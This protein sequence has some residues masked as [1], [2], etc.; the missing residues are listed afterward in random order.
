MEYHDLITLSEDPSGSCEDDGQGKGD[1]STFGLW[2][3]SRGCY[4]NLGEQCRSQGQGG[5][6]NN[7]AERSSLRAPLQECQQDL[8]MNR[9]L[10]MVSQTQDDLPVLSLSRGEKMLALYQRLDGGTSLEGVHSSEL[11]FCSRYP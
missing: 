1:C 2:G 9:M 10:G 6:K 4:R 8:R 5:S 3:S 11:E 7:R